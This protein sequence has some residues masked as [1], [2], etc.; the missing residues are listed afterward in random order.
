MRPRSNTYRAVL[1]AVFANQDTG[2]KFELLT[3]L[4]AATIDPVRA[5]IYRLSRLK[6][7]PSETTAQ[8]IYEGQKQ[9][10]R[11][12][13]D[14]ARR[15]GR[16]S[17]MDTDAGRTVF[18]GRPATTGGRHAKSRTWAEEQLTLGSTTTDPT[19]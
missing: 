9:I 13:I 12:Y 10:G 18:L 3:N 16:I 8:T 19:D 17:Y 14:A 2:I 1:R 5:T 15:S 11:K 6:R 7:T 4:A